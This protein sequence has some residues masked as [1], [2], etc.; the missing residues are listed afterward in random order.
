LLNRTKKILWVI[1]LLSCIILGESLSISAIPTTINQEKQTPELFHI[2]TVYINI[3]VSKTAFDPAVFTVKESATVNLTVESID[4]GHTFEIPEYAIAETVPA[5]GTVNIVFEATQL[6]NF[7]YSSVNS[8]A[9]GTMIVEEAYVPDMPRP[10]DI[11]IIFD[12]KH[13]SDSEVV[14]DKYSTIFNWTRDNGF[15]SFINY[16]QELSEPTLKGNDILIIFE[17]NVNF[18]EVELKDIAEFIENGGSLII[19]GSVATAFTNAYKLL[20]PFGI[21]FSNAT[22]R[23]INSTNPNPIGVNDTLAEFT[24]SNFVLDHPILSENQYVPLTDEIVTHIRYTGTVLEYNSSLAMTELGKDNLTETGNLVDTYPFAVGNNSIFADIDG[25]ITVD[26]NETIGTNNTLMVLAEMASNARLCALGSADMFNNS[27]VGRYAEN[28][29]FFQRV[30]QWVAKMYAVI[31]SESFTVSSFSLKRGET[32]NSSVSF[33]TQNHTIITDINA[34]IRVWRLALVERSFNLINV[35]NS[36]FSCSIDTQTIPRGTFEF[37]AIAHKRGFGYNIT[38]RFAVEI[39]PSDP[40]PLPV[41]AIYIIT[42]SLSAGI[43][44]VA[45]A[46]FA[47]SLAQKPKDEQVSEEEAETATKEEEEADLNEYET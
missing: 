15:Q 32:L 44:V 29:A 43:G 34:T 5:N 33:F 42:F 47:K 27:M 36:Y 19:G 17:P 37:E 8:T 20:E 21:G 28:A 6:G 26:E 3:T 7:T 35:N 18:T 24:L 46:F 22:A 25:D 30:L 9:T 14:R 41:S 23:Y 45:I 1:A 38:S 10:E 12:Y 39:F 2:G 4:V 16:G 11:F 31:Q 40:E 13:N